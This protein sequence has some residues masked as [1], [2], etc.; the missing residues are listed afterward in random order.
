MDKIEAKQMIAE[1][2]QRYRAKHYQELSQMIAIEP[3]IYELTSQSD[4]TYQI[5]IQAFWDDQPNG[6][7]RVIANIADG[8]FRAFFP[9]TD[10]FIKSPHNEFVGE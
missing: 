2:L 4:I 3:I 6:N 5:E 10:D 1:Q 9:L 8:G 7:I